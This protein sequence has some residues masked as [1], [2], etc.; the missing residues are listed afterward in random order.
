MAPKRLPSKRPRLERGKLIEQA[1][2]MVAQEQGVKLSMQYGQ[3]ILDSD[4]VGKVRIT[5]SQA[6]ALDALFRSEITGPATAR[7]LGKGWFPGMFRG[8]DDLMQAAKSSRQIEM[9][10]GQMSSMSEAVRKA[11]AN[12]LITP[13]QKLAL[14]NLVQRLQDS[15]ELLAP[16]A[17]AQRDVSNLVDAMTKLSKHGEYCD[18][19]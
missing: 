9:T 10:Q 2:G 17:R 4:V 11:A 12:G 14:N 7:E 13:S 8:I 6:R 15:A 5:S 16:E 3:P 18:F 1:K 19:L